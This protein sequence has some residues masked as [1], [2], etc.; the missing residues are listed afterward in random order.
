[1]GRHHNPNLWEN[2]ERKIERKAKAHRIRRAQSVEFTLTERSTK[3]SEAE[4]TSMLNLWV[5]GHRLGS[6]MVYST[7]EREDTLIKM[8]KILARQ[9]WCTNIVTEDTL[10][11]FYIERINDLTNRYMNHAGYSRHIREG[12]DDYGQDLVGQSNPHQH[13]RQDKEIVTEIRNGK[14][15]HQLSPKQKPTPSEQR[16]AELLAGLTGLPWQYNENA[17]CIEFTGKPRAA[18]TKALQE[19]E[20]CGVELDGPLETDKS[21]PR[22]VLKPGYN[23][24]ALQLEAKFENAYD[25][26]IQAVIDEPETTIN[27]SEQKGKLVSLSKKTHGR[28]GD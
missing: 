21:R 7:K 17:R 3:A 13:Y 20:S 5:N 2:F 8:G 10:Y 25:R 15:H 27:A 16:I 9:E 24:E 12:V 1:M 14:L 4:P 11:E 19:L 6:R 18:Q 26:R 28:T 23:V 22:Y